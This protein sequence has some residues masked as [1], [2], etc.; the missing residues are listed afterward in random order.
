M[1][2]IVREFKVICHTEP[3]GDHRLEGYQ[4]GETYRIEEKSDKNGTYWKVF[5][6]ADHDYGEIIGSKNIFN[7][8]FKEVK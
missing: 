3:K 2:S 1:M 6:V 8:Y 5:P 4:R 7:K